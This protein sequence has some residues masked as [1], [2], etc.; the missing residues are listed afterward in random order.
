MKTKERNQIVP[1]ALA[2]A[3]WAGGVGTAA[4]DHAPAPQLVAK[5]IPLTGLNGP[6]SSVTVWVPAA[7]TKTAGETVKTGE[8]VAKAVPL[9]ASNGPAQ[10]ATVWTP[11]V[12]NGFYVAPLK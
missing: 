6:M 11:T 7:E 9:P 1:L 3:V 5:V 2:L 10:S 12:N 4:A 8:T